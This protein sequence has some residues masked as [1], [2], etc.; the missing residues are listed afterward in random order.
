MIG[1]CNEIDEVVFVIVNFGWSV[2]VL[3][4]LLMMGE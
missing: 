1:R 2:L 3:C 4:V